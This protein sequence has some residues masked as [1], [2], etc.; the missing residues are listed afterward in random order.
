MI[1]EEV[2]RQLNE[3]LTVA[4]WEVS[5]TDPDMSVLTLK[6]A[7]GKKLPIL[8]AKGNQGK[9]DFQFILQQ[10]KNY[11]SN[12]DSKAFID[13]LVAKNKIRIR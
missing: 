1:K 10:L 9:R 8:Q 7:G 4:D 5:N 2:R 12:A 11:K 6:F 3:S 13:G